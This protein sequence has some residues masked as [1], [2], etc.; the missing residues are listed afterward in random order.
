MRVRATT[1]KFPGGVRFR[2]MLAIAA[3]F[4]A[5]QAD[6]PR[7][8]LAERIDSALVQEW[9]QQGLVPAL[10]A[11]DATW[12]RRLSLDLCGA[13]P[14]PGETERFLADPSP[15]K[16]ER[17]IDE[18]L[19]DRRF[20]DN[21]A[22][23][24]SDLLLSAS[25]KDAL[26]TEPWILAFLEEEFAKGTS[27]ATITELLIRD[28]GTREEP[29]SLGFILSYRDAI[30]TL[31]GVTA[32]AFL[33]LQI[34][35]AQCHDHPYD[36]WKQDDF[37]RFTGFFYDMRADH[38]PGGKSKDGLFRVDDSSPER[39]LELRVRRML[40]GRRNDA[41]PSMAPPPTGDDETDEARRKRRAR[42]TKASKTLE[43][44]PSME[45]TAE[46]KPEG[47]PEETPDMASMSSMSETDDAT[48]I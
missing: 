26:R 45:G 23:I 12:L 17:K 2:A 39:N 42:R 22:Q 28:S 40:S 7:Q 13:I 11:D 35:C 31:S 15:D 9:K 27:F 43:P 36:T 3:L 1:R 16:R 34:Q 20:A 21:Q 8:A 44:E 46:E 30:E 37:N 29:G 14:R 33:G 6:D 41:D 10:S 38:V 24:W 19:A 4:I 47:T 5:L 32:R 25:G 48:P 18:Y